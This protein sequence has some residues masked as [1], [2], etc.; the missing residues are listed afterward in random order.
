MVTLGA[1]VLFPV[2]MTVM[3]T[4][5]GLLAARLLRSPL[6]GGLLPAVGACLGVV[7]SLPVYKLHLGAAVAAPL[8]AVLAVIGFVVCRRSLRQRL[9]PGW[10]ALAGLAGFLMIL[11]PALLS[12]HWTWSG[13]NF[14]NDTATNMLLVDHIAHHGIQPATGPASTAGALINGTLGSRYPMGI[15][16]LL[17]SVHGVLWFLPLEAVYQP[18]I[19][20]LAGLAAMALCVLAVRGG[21]A[22]PFAAVLGAVAVCGAL[23]YGYALHGAF[24]EIAVVLVLCASAALGRVV[25]D[26]ELHAGTT[27][28]LGAV[29]A[30]AVVI[31]SSAAVPY[32]A[33]EAV[34]LLVAA[35]L[36]P[37][38][39]P[40]L[41]IAQAAAA[42]IGAL[43]IA[44]LPGLGDALA[45]GK[46]AEGY[47]TQS[48]AAVQ[49][50][51]PALLGHLLRPLPPL[52]AVGIWLA[53]DYRIVLVGARAHLTLA[54]TVLAVALIVVVAVVEIARRRLVALLLCIPALLVYLVAAPRL[55]PYAEAKLLV[56]LT[57]ALVFSAGWGAWWLGR[58]TQI[59]GILAALALGGGVLATDALL[60]HQNKLAPT[61][62]LTALEQAFD[63]AP[64][65]GG[66]VL[67]P[68]WEEFGK[69]LG[70]DREVNVGAET[71]SPRY[72]DMRVPGPTFARSFDLDELNLG[73]VAS[74]PFIVVRTGPVV[75]RPPDGFTL[76]Y[77]NRFYQLWRRAAGARVVE[78]LA[79]PSSPAATAA[80]APRCSDV[81]ALAS[82]ATGRQEI[83]AAPAGEVAEFDY[84]AHPPAGWNPS[85]VPDTVIPM[86]PGSAQ[87]RVSV[88]GGRYRVWLRGGSGRALHVSVDGRPLPP[89]KGIDTP[90]GWL[91]VGDVE[92][93][94]G[95]H[96]VRLV[97]PGGGLAPGDGFP[98]VVGPVALQRA[99]APGLVSVAPASAS[100]R[101]CGRAWDWIERVQP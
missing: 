11:A 27:A 37:P 57:P 95:S 28:L 20:V 2:V 87:G 48:G 43:F 54:L 14:V 32:V 70:R 5:I 36:V 52:E 46:G 16:S 76:V 35:V 6:P 80:G 21:M 55:A 68:E 93:R 71:F 39:P 82:R 73:Y 12:G 64:R 75:S 22:A 72:L 24:K 69:Y 63:H 18:F 34:V 10:S 83:V 44:A 29:L 65:G 7:L 4:G 61:G 90:S 92:L 67:F 96:D 99:E 50:N 85:P 25:L 30:A 98:D 91:P 31:Y 86:R 56:L 74:F 60:Y 26:A 8:L 13:Y 40:A 45:F 58:V 9:R 38:R 77:Q 88:A 17:A 78:H 94:P 49:G 53:G 97:R 51:A 101:L 33:V 41:R 84:T 81:R 19:A 1:F 3:A 47:F 15:H 79:L 59:A 66:M 23:S 62:R 89:V 42:G 100:A